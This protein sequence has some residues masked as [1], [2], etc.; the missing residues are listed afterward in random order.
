MIF[1]RDFN[2]IELKDIVQSDHVVRK[3]K[4]SFPDALHYGEFSTYRERFC[5]LFGIESERALRLLHKTQ[6][7]KNLEDI[8]IFLR[9]YMLDKPETFEVADRLVNEFGE[10]NEAH[11]S[12]V[13]ARKQIQTLTP[14]SIKGQCNAAKTCG[15]D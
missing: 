14:G 15:T 6:S 5:Y 2:L 10:L 7:A 8:N 3:L 4:Q 12:V 11:Q 9:D 13:T 1:E